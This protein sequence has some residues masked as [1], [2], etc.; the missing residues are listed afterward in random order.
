MNGELTGLDLDQNANRR[1]YEIFRK[2]QY[3]VHL[4]LCPMNHP[5]RN[6]G[7]EWHDLSVGR[8]TFGAAGVEIELLPF[9]EESQSFV[10]H[11]LRLTDA[12]AIS[13][14]LNGH[15]TGADLEGLEISTFAFEEQTE[16]ISGTFSFIPGSP[17]V[18]YW[19][20]GFTNARWCLSKHN[21]SFNPDALTRAG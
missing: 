17:S 12:E 9:D 18:G 11:L 20:L 10:C 7:F 5:L 21:C 14:N 15:L 3:D 4:S 8:L 19:E 16:R 6:A 13:F 2:R 1:H